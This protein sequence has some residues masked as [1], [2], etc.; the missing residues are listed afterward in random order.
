METIELALEQDRFYKKLSFLTGF[1]L[2]CG[3]QQWVMH[4]T[5]LVST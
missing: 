3:L 5:V 4:S 1:M 2:H